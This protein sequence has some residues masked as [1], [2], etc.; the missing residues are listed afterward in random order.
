MNINVIIKYFAYIS[1]HSVCLYANHAV[2]ET[3]VNSNT[4][5]IRTFQIHHLKIQ[6]NLPRRVYLFFG[7]INGV[8]DSL[9]LFMYKL[10]LN[11]FVV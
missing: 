10:N 11:D 3:R 1:F 7:D 5:H 2:E 9:A 6:Q 4:R 8:S